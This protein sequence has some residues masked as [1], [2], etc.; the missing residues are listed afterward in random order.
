M[1]FGDV[2]GYGVPPKPDFWI[3]PREADQGGV[4]VLRARAA[5]TAAST[6]AVT[7]S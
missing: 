2:I 6:R 1:Q 5:S 4:D 7:R 3:A